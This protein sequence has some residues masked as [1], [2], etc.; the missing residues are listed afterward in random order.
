MTY[1]WVVQDPLTRHSGGNPPTLTVAVNGCR[2]S[3]PSP[4]VSTVMYDS[5]RPSVMVPA[6][7][8]HSQ[9]GVTLSSPPLTFAVK[10]EGTPDESS[11]GQLTVTTGHILL[12][13]C[14]W[15][16]RGTTTPLP[17]GRSAASETMMSIQGLIGLGLYSFNISRSMM[18]F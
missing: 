18:S 14:S 17:A 13:P 3:Y 11:S 12:P 1:I 4:V 10:T 7:T 8:P 2:S 9:V 6:E 15:G 5:P 16:R